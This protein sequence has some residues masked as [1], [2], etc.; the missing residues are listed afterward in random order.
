MENE[1]IL[2]DAELE[3]VAGGA[4]AAKA[5]WKWVVCNVE[6]NYLALRSAPEYK[7][8]NEKVK[9]YPGTAFEIRTDKKSGVYVWARFNGTEGWV[10]GNY[11]KTLKI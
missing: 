10:N 4:A 5:K 11:V 7:F 8:E 1:K 9:I 6:K 3:Q 2:N